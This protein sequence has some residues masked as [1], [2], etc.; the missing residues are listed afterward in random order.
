[1][2]SFLPMAAA[3]GCVYTIRKGNETK[4]G[5]VF[6]L[7]A[8]RSGPHWNT[9]R[10]V[11]EGVCSERSIW[12]FPQCSRLVT[13]EGKRKSTCPTCSINIFSWTT[14]RVPHSLNCILGLYMLLEGLALF[15][16]FIFLF[17]CITHL[18]F[19]MKFTEWNG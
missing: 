17:L 1:M 2:A 8:I 11:D 14:L 19:F 4:K 7:V 9:L 12:V 18:F 16:H 15:I 3:G 13:H 5:R 10:D 6:F